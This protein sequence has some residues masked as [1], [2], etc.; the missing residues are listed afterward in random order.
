MIPFLLRSRRSKCR[1]VLSVCAEEPFFSDILHAFEDFGLDI[2]FSLFA[3]AGAY[4]PFALETERLGTAEKQQQFTNGF[5]NA[6]ERGEMRA[7]VQL[8]SAYGMACAVHSFLHEAMHIYQDM[9]GLFFVPLKEQGMIPVALDDKSNIVAIL[10][11]EAWAQVQAIRFSYS[12]KEKG[13]EAAWKGACMHPDF[14]YLAHEYHADLSGGIEEKEAA[15]RCFMRWY[16]G[17]HRSFYEQHALNIF[18]LNF[19]RL[20]RDV[21]DLAKDIVQSC[22]RKLDVSVLPPRVSENQM[23]DFFPY[24]DWNSE[25]LNRVQDENV[26]DAVRAFEDQ[27]GRAENTDIADIRCGSP[28]YIWNRLRATEIDNFDVPAEMYEMA[29]AGMG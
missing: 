3:G 24:V 1:K 12:L 22:L 23:T 8:S 16:A 6:A 15:A 20:T 17:E 11:C 21:P 27:Y 28:V 2:R 25:V 7:Q 9:Y 18:Q 13:H 14:A 29:K 10:F 5:W 4:Q 26:R 19:E